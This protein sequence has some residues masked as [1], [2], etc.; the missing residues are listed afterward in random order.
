MQQHLFQSKQLID[1]ALFFFAQANGNQISN[2]VIFLHRQ[3]ALTFQPNFIHQPVHVPFL[4]PTKRKKHPKAILNKTQQA[5]SVHLLQ[6]Q[7]L[8]QLRH[9]S[10]L[11]PSLSGSA[12]VR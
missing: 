7:H 9:T 6:R 11:Q 2:L 4:H 8:H 1:C 5:P 10:T 12:F 3:L